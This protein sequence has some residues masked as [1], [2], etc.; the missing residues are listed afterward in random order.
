MQSVRSFGKLLVWYIVVYRPLAWC[1][2]LRN[3]IHRMA[4]RFLFLF[5]VVLGVLFVKLKSCKLVISV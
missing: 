3:Y 1:L 4:S 5:F 2:C